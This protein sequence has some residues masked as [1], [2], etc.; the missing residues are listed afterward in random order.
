MS[1]KELAASIKMQSMKIVEELIKNQEE[2][3]ENE[4]N[5]CTICYCNEI[6]RNDSKTTVIL[7]CDHAFCS[8]CTLS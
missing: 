6:D 8:D 1:K 2:S 5:Y 3:N 4:K 7:D